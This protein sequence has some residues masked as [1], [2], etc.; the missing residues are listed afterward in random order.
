MVAF[1]ECLRQLIQHTRNTK[2]RAADGS[3][4][5]CPQ[6]PYVIEKDRIEDVS[7]KLGGFN[8]EETWTKACKWT[9]IFCNYLLAHASNTNELAPRR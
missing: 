2:I 4:I 9:L 1:L 3:L 8:N 6:I 7:I 5:T